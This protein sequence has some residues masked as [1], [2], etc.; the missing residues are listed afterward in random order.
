MF[1][2]EKE[3]AERSR[4]LLKNKETRKVK[5]DVCN[6]PATPLDSYLMSNVC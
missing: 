5:S 2:K 1:K 4:A 3:L 6:N